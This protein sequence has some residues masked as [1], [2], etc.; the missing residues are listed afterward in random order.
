MSTYVYYTISSVGIV[1]E[2]NPKDA[3]ALFNLCIK[4]T[5]Q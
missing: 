2:G 5:L 1:A 4:Q 3:Q